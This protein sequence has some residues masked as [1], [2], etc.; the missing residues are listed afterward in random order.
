[1]R[2]HVAKLAPALLVGGCSLLYNPNN[3]GKAPIDATDAPS[4]DAPMTADADIDAPPLA[5][6]NPGM[7]MLLDVM[8]KVIY[9]GQGQFNSRPAIV[10]LRGHHFV[11]EGLTVDITPS[12]GLTVSAPTVSMNGDYIALTIA[13]DVDAATDTGTMPLTITVN[14]NGAPAGG[15]TLADALS[16]QYLPQLTTGGTVDTNTLAE[17]YA[18]V[19]IGDVTFT[20]TKAAIVRSVSR[21]KIGNIVANGGAGA[22]GSAG[23]AG[24]G[25]CAGGGS[26]ATGGCTPNDGG[27]GGAAATSGGAGGG[28]A[29]PGGGGNGGDGGTA[30][31]EHGNAQ[32]VSYTGAAGQANQS[33]GGGGGSANLL[34]NAGGGGGGGGTV[35]LTAG[36]DIMV[37]AISANGGNGGNANA[38]LTAGGGGGGGSGGVV[39]VRSA[40]GAV[41]VAGIS[42]M[43]G[44]AGAKAGSGG[45]GGTGGPGRVRVDVA[46]GG[47][48]SANPEA[49]RGPAFVNVPTIVTSK[50]LAFSMSGND[51]DVVDAFVIPD[52]GTVHTGEPMDLSFSN[53]SL[54]FSGVLLPGYNKFC[55]T[56]EPGTR[57]HADKLA[58][59]C[60][61]VAYL[62]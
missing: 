43:G 17:L 29:A 12:T 48:P 19:N 47:L 44:A 61:D 46:S 28:F 4:I 8:P 50:G 36:G 54:M 41:A 3:I 24:P 9:E 23:A 10:V 42:A 2:Q 39:V 40:A 18:D 35:E 58:D 6:A 53:G 7:L 62:P 14:E 59:T 27:G 60:V 25:G 33:A 34:A 16:V 31:V 51:G 21:I 37:G 11:G 15:V 1:M 30:G 52:D 26:G 45:G 55:V 20:G 57:Q 5:D 56:L 49:H 13:V 38:L 32:L 22:T